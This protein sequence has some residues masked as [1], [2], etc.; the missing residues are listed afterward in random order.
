MRRFGQDGYHNTSP[1]RVARDAGIA[2]AG[3]L[4]HFGGKQQLLQAVVE[5]RHHQLDERRRRGSDSVRDAFRR[6]VEDMQE[7]PCAVGRP[8]PERTSPRGR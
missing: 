1:A 3:L 6:H 5:Y 2:D 7:V 8:G 4:H